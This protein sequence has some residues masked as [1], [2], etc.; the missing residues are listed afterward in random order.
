MAAEVKET[1]CTKCT[2]CTHQVVCRYKKDLQKVEQE[3]RVIEATADVA[4]GLISVSV[5]C[6]LFVPQVIKSRGDLMGEER[7]YDDQEENR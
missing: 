4:A 2:K 3:V 5:D 6:S 7:N 1:K